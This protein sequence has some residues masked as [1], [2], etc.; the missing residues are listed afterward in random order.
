MLLDERNTF[1]I[2]KGKMLDQLFKTATVAC[3]F[4]EKLCLPKA[5][6]MPC[7]LANTY[8]LVFCLSHWTQFK[9]VY[10]GVTRTMQHLNAKLL[11]ILKVLTYI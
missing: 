11:F 9:R 4:A 10:V 3:F 7:A 6:A 5:M 1:F 2:F 8:P